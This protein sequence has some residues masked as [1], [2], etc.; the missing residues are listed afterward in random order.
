M[1][2]TI[3]FFDSG[4]GGIPYLI[5]LRNI[6]SDFNYVYLADNANFPYGIKT[7]ETIKEIVLSAIGRFIE[8]T[9]PDVIVIACNTATVVT[10]PYLREKYNIPFVGV[11][12]AV[13]P[14]ASI[15]EN[16]RIGLFATNKT[17]S[18]SYTD[19]L[20]S[21]FAGNCEVYKYA[22]PNIVSF[23]ENKMFESDNKEIM[24]F[25]LPAANYFIEKDVDHVVLGCTHF[26]FIHDTLENLFPQKIKIIDSREGVSR[27]VLRIISDTDTCARFSLRRRCAVSIEDTAKQTAWDSDTGSKINDSAFYLTSSS[28]NNDYYKKIA[29]RFM[30]KYSG[31]I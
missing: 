4:I 25:L 20:I 9:S 8:K 19:N 18:D 24:D 5:H 26:L 17:V 10:L 28:V 29:E 16:K 2:K 11:V 30:I 1:N 3:A 31:I 13:K 7:G 12:P 14:A 21:Q 27:Q 15:S 6:K 22:D 23:I